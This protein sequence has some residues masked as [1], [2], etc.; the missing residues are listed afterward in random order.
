LIGL[1]IDFK[2]GNELGFGMGSKVLGIDLIRV[3]CT[4]FWIVVDFIESLGLL[5][6]FDFLVSSASI[7][8]C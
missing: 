3:S 8:D 5:K 2:G 1:G 6:G 4:E 7:K